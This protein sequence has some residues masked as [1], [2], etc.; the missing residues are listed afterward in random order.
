MKIMTIGNG[1]VADHLPYELINEK[2]SLNNGWIRAVLDDYQPDVL[3]N[4]IGKT[5]RPNIDWCENNKEITAKTNTLLPV[6]LAEECAKKSIHMIQIGSGC[7][8]FG[9]SPNKNSHLTE[10]HDNTIKPGDSNYFYSAFELADAG[11]KEEDFANPKSF[12]SKSKYACDLM[13]GSMEH[14]TTLRIRMPISTKNNPRNLINKLRGYKQVIDIPNSMT[15]MDDLTRCVDWAAK[16]RH[17]GIFHVTNPGPITAVQII[18][19]YQKHVP[20]HSFEIIDEAQLDSLTVA[21]RS[22]CIINSDKLK[23]AGFTMTPSK[24][25]LKTCMAEY[26]KNIGD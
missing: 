25:A 24:E 21:K 23:N 5:G 12:Y 13:L 2:L 6:L 8:Y 10:R 1:F 15:F 4:C 9:E 11:W 7:I 16:G 20:S 14:V 22:N 18:K 19:E 3:I 17:T 26:I